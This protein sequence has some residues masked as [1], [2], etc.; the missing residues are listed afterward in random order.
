[1]PQKRQSHRIK[2]GIPQIAEYEYKVDAEAEETN[3]PFVIV[4]PEKDSVSNELVQI[5]GRG[6]PRGLQI[7]LVNWIIEN[8]C[9]LQSEV[10]KPDSNGDWVIRKCHLSAIGKE[11]FVYALAVNPNDVKRIQEL[12]TSTKIMN[13]PDMEDNLRKLKIKYKISERK[14]LIRVQTES[15]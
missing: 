15:E 11:R 10:S 12:F 13:I 8:R 4:R 9:Y 7:L 6:C 3:L 5:D 14:R 2:I 1:M